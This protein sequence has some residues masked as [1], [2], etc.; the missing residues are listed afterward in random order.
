MKLDEFP[1]GP[2]SPSIL[3][4]MDANAEC[5][6][7]GRCAFDPTPACGC[8]PVE[9]SW[10]SSNPLITYWEPRKPEKISVP[11]RL[12]DK[13]LLRLYV[14][15]IKGESVRSLARSILEPH[16]Y[17]SVESAKNSII[18][19]WRTRGLA[20]MPRAV[21]S[22]EARTA[23]RQPGSPGTGDMPEWDRWWRS[24]NG[25]QR[26]CAGVKAYY[27]RKG[28]RCKGWA[29]DGSDFCHQHDPNFAARRAELLKR[30]RAA[31]QIERVERV[32]LDIA[33]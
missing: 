21:A 7:H 3:E 9:T 10:R 14:R 20:P 15:H 30:M 5:R 23:S 24:K 19:G 13:L 16:G 2:G 8:F 31:R 12:G 28:E 1:L 29:M 25:R 17:G 32:E 4:M 6:E 11:H 26:Q 33:A 18:G 27:P 22:A